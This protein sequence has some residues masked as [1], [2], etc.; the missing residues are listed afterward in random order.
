MVRAI[1]GLI[2][3]TLLVVFLGYYAYRIGSIPLW[4]IIVGIL[5]MAIADYV[6]SVITGENG[7][8]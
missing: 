3:V 4:M 5:A 8:K 7:N 6:Q 1:T 2:G